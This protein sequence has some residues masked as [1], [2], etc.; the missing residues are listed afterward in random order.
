[1]FTYIKAGREL[2]RT[3]NI[4]NI[5]HKVPGMRNYVFNIEQ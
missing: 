2:K 4:Q 5:F 1:M 3:K